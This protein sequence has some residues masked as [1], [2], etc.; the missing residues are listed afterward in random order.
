MDRIAVA[1]DQ[2]ADD[3]R[4]ETAAALG[5]DLGRR[6]GNLFRVG[7]SLVGA[8]VHVA[9]NRAFGKDEQLGALPAASSRRARQTSRFRSFSAS[10]GSICATATF[11]S[12]AS[13]MSDFRLAEDPVLNGMPGRG[14][15]EEG[16]TSL[17]DLATVPTVARDEGQYP[18]PRG[19]Q[20]RQQFRRL[21]P[22]QRAVRL[23][24][25]R[26]LGRGGMGVV[27]LAHQ[28]GLDRMVGAQAAR[29]PPGRG[30]AL[31]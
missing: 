3:V 27:Y 1:L 15:Q 2:T 26:V 17:T 19:G 9:R 4:A 14:G 23:R 13:L 8:L 30:R 28:L 24:I 11:I 5:E 7:R 10:F 18:P 20:R 12:K 21:A 31:P 16:V 22:R 29:P 25:E 6:A